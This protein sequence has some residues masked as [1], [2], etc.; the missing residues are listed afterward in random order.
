MTRDSTSPVAALSVMKRSTLYLLGVLSAVKA[1]SIIGL[2][3]ALSAGIVTVIGGTGELE[4][5]V[6]LGL[7]SALLRAFVAWAHRTVATRAL[8]GTKER[9]RA[10]LA[11]RALEQSGS[12]PGSLATL[13]TQG[14]D[15]LDKYF[16]V[17]LPAL[18]TAATVPLLIGARILFADW[19][20]AVIIVLTVPLIPL[21]MVLIGLRTQE[22][23]A[24]ATTAL[25]RLS[26][27]LVELARGLPVL[28]G[29]GRAGEQVAALRVISDG[30]RQKTVQTLRT[31]FLSALA[32][33]LIATISV[34]V[35]A[36]FI[37]VRLVAGDLSLE[38][39]LLVLILAPECMTPFREIGVAFHASQDGR[40]AISRTRA[41]LDAPRTSSLIESSVTESTVRV[42]RL[43]VRYADRSSA[44]LRDLSFD[45]R[46]GE[47]TVLDGRSGTGKSTVFRVLAGRLVTSEGIEVSGRVSGIDGERLAWL[48]QHPHT[49]ADTVLD[50]M[51]LYAPQSAEADE[52]ARGALSR[53]GLAHLAH[54]DTGLISPGEL[55]RL[56]FG[57][58]LMRV[59][60]GANV[61]LLD[62][63]TSQL[64]AVSARSVLDEI[65]AMKPGVTVILASHEPAARAIAD[66]RVLLSGRVRDESAQSVDSAQSATERNE[67]A[68]AIRVRGGDEESSHP[69]RELRAFLRPVAGR[70]LV[71][72]VLGTLAALFALALTALSGWLIVRASEHPPIMYLLV[73]IVGVRFFGIGRAVLRYSERLLGHNAVF[74][75]LTELRMRLWSGLASKGPRSRDLLTGGS[76]L[77]RLVRDVDQI[78]DLSIR[79]V[80]PLS[81]G[82]ATLV[83]T[84]AALG[85]LAPVAL[86]L[87]IAFGLVAG[88]VAPLAALWADRRASRGQQLLKSTVLRR[89]AA[90][91]GAADELRANGVDGRIRKQLG[92][93]DAEAGAT[94]RRSAWALGLGGAVVVAACAITSIL[95]LPVAASTAIAPGLVAILALVPLG[96]IDPLLDLV[97]AVQASPAL[98]E[99]LGR[100]SRITAD[101]HIAIRPEFA[102]QAVERLSLE[103][104]AV[105]WPGS[106]EFVTQNVDAEVRRGEW[107]VVTGPSG[108]GKSSLLAILLGQLEPAAGR[109]TINGQD[110]AGR[111]L[112]PLAP[113]FGWCPQEG[114]LF[115]ST[116]RANLLL[117]RSREDAPDDREMTSM[118]HRVG[119]GPLLERLP[120]GLDTVIGAEAGHLSGGERQRVAIARTLL[121]KADVILIDE[122]TAHLD[123]ESAE[124][125]MAD[126]RAALADR[127]TVLVTHHANGIR[128]GDARIDLGALAQGLTHGQTQVMP[129]AQSGLVVSGAA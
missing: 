50:E 66:R 9:L 73:A 24:E 1:L 56:A 65:A 20:S 127:I 103:G 100:V 64:D 2:A 60:A 114:H 38:V 128:P 34:A 115:N 109:Y 129:T 39:G 72:V 37:G 25:G 112:A 59:A 18:V 8:L 120:G 98:R 22:K 47:I 36:V 13:A 44:S 110:T 82:S 79:V 43:S 111:D 12:L 57:R 91:L 122:P 61:V 27:H 26:D 92:R 63:P 15:E 101:P 90:M 46:P 106:A 124:A 77:D 102:S 80:L 49:S 74:A 41:I 123:D 118:L 81:I 33:E 97:A 93:L 85:T 75:A 55:R 40:E 16:T 7:G 62:E 19:V 121:T 70:I 108:S 35:V 94:A 6:A 95:M 84:I 67:F 107:L 88:I 125:L 3:T 5:L 52:L 76:T 28:V 14:L 83:I 105:R 11:E 4:P 78:R 113:S 42:H 87:L 54:A 30:H 29:L 23:V 53:L 31:A 17:F 21:F 86:P 71:T 126:L 58:V 117:A 96:L 99:V 68:R 89:F 10:Q 119:L 116:L 45:A 104:V 32:L 48:P 69:L 51:M